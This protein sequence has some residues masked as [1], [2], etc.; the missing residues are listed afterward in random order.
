MNSTMHSSK[1]DKY[2]KTKITIKMDI[3]TERQRLARNILDLEHKIVT[4][5]SVKKRSEPT[6]VTELNNWKKELKESRLAYEALKKKC[7]KK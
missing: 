4:W 3:K 1:S 7:D 5:D 6:A 2:K